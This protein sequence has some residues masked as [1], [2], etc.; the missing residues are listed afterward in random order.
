MLLLNCQ[1]SR[2][3]KI[4]MFETVLRKVRIFFFSECWSCLELNK[5]LTRFICRP[6]CTWWLC[7]K[8][9]FLTTLRV[10]Q[11]LPLRR[12]LP[13]PLIRVVSVRATHETNELDWYR[14]SWSPGT[15]IFHTLWYWITSKRILID[16]VKIFQILLKKHKRESQDILIL[17]FC[18]V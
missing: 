10:L 7:Y 18:F 17:T 12:H 9:M 4:C 11:R 8:N 2:F 13:L 6:Y 1:M 16:A 3:S 14:E 15:A 5:I